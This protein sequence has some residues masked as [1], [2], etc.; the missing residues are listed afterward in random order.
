MILGF[1]KLFLDK[2]EP[3]KSLLLL[4]V[5]INILMKYVYNSK[6]LDI[7]INQLDGIYLY[8]VIVQFS[9]IEVDELSINRSLLL[10]KMELSTPS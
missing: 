5:F 8:Q 2:I 7:Q 10:N 3:F 6:L 1:D 9:V 4:K